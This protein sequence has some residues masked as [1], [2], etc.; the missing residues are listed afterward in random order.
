MK[1]TSQRARVRRGEAAGAYRFEVTY[2]VGP[3]GEARRVEVVRD[4]TVN[5]A[6][7]VAAKSVD[8]VVADLPYGVQHSA[9][10]GVGE[11]VDAAVPGWVSVLRPGGAMALAC[12]VRTLPRER[13]AQVLVGAGLTVLE[14]EGFEHR[15]DRAITRDVVVARRP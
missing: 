3:G 7:H 11:L 2:R 13:L 12:N 6:L 8:V 10:V 5:T 1:H 4:D 9:G 15:V 14:A